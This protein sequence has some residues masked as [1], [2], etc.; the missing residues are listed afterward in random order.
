MANAILYLAQAPKSNRAYMALHAATEAAA[1]HPDAPVPLA[2]RN[3]TTGL[4]KEWGYG[5][6]TSTHTATR[7]PSSTSS[8][9]PDVI[10][11]S[12]FYEP[13]DR[14]FEREVAAR[15]AER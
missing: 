12:R 13:S 14:G 6:D 5:K 15:M 7:A 3:A 1:Q 10:A 8:A 4:M 2:L 11:D 9:S